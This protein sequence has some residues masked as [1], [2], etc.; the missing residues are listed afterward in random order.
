[1]LKVT[2]ALMLFV[3][4]L[5]MS[6]AVYAQAPT[7]T[8]SGTVTDESGAIIPNA[9]ITITAKGT[10][11]TRTATTN[12]EGVFN[13]SAIPAGD[14]EV[15]SEVQG[16]RTTLREATV[17]AGSSTTVNL[18]MQLGATKDVVTVEAATAQVNYDTHN[19]EGVI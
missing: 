14:Y 19:I 3:L 11:I 7:G 16:F 12:A 1:M 4:V 2:S 6:V 17:L 9:T 5:A 10:G 15:R 13:A 18:P 8:I